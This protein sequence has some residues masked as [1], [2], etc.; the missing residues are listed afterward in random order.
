VAV[1]QALTVISWFENLPKEEQ[2]PRAIW[3]S[4]ELVD[5]WFRD[6]EKKR[7]EKYGS[8]GKR[9]TSYEEADSV[10]MSTNEL[11]DQYRQQHGK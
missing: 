9:K 10:P 5:S 6:V 2:P 7:S 3:H 11:A 1:N 8:S 4:A